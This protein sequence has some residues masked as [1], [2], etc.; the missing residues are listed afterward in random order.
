MPAREEGGRSLRW[1]FQQNAAGGCQG[2][3]VKQESIYCCHRS[4]TLPKMQTGTEIPTGPIGE[5][6]FIIIFLFFVRASFRH[7][8]REETHQNEA[9]DITF[10]W[11]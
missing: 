6:I 2:L 9:R 10:L 5:L 11:W 1:L 4:L 3:R 8:I 7:A